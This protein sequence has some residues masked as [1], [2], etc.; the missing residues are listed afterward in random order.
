M[1]IRSVLSMLMPIVLR[2]WCVDTKVPRERHRRRH[3][4]L[5]RAMAPRIYARDGIRGSISHHAG[6]GY[7]DSL[8][9]R[10]D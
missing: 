10:G 2:L 4:R 1:T 8:R 7:G 9:R 6:G 5:A 3:D